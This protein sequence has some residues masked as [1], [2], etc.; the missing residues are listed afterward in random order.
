M[1]ETVNS[2]KSSVWQ[3]YRFPIILIIS[4]VIGSVVGL[5]MGEKSAMLK[6]F[7]DIFLNLMFTVVVP[8]VFITIASAVAN[9]TNM[10][11][12]KK[13]LGYMLLTFFITGI[14]AALYIIPAVKIF[15]PAA[16]VNIPMPAA[17]AI[18]KMTLGEQIVKAITVSD[19]YL[20]LSRR[21]ML[22]LIVFALLFGFCV[23]ALG[24]DNIVTKG[25]DALSVVMMK[26]IDV[27]MLYAPIGLGAYFASLVGEFGPQLLGAYARALAL[28]YPLCLFYFLTAF[29]AYAWFSA[30]KI[31]VRA[32]Y[33]H[34]LPPVITSLATQS[35]IATLPV[36]FEASRKI[37]IPKD[38]SNIVL[39]IGATAHM[40]GSVI[41]A[42]LKISFLFG[43]FGKEFAGMD[44]YLT[45]MMISILA[46]VVL[47]GVPGGG[48]VG[49]MLIV[50]LMG[51]PAEAFP[52]I[53]TIG[54]LVDPPAT[55]L[56][57]TG[58]TVAS[59]VVTRLIEG[60]DWLRKKVEAKE[61]EI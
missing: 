13:I 4:I 41:A 29:T 17:E 36:N 55:C 20:L 51:F 27:I 31:G 24:K 25:L 9:M 21:N 2:S 40:D 39:P 18:E 15:P 26:I 53:A 52:L 43:V 37:G 33:R 23:S 3:S 57:S 50:N 30:G 22:P 19:F 6:P 56:N 38:I 5:V 42:I 54:F 32:F 58:D 60:K 14:I 47:S 44:V 8:L 34:I 59:M 46:G 7:G 48:L 11:R 28:Y 1:S 61:I 10:T 12:L 49:E 35:S 45:S 16:G